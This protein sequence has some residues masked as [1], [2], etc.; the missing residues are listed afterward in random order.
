MTTARAWLLAA[1]VGLLCGTTSAVAQWNTCVIRNATSSG[2]PPAILDNNNYA[3]PAKEFVISEGGQK[4]AWGTSLLDGFAVKDIG[5]I[6]VTRF[7]DRTRFTA[8][9]GP[10][11][12]PYF[13]IWITD[14]T[15]KYAVIA[16]E[17]SDPIFQPLYSNGYNLTWA[18]IADKPAKVYE[19]ADKSW[20]PNNGVGLT[21]NDVADYV[22]QAPTVAE[23][24]TGWA[25]LG[26]GAP[27]ELG[28]NIAYGFNWVLGDTLSNYV[29]GDPGYVLAQPAAVPA[30][31]TWQVATVHGCAQFDILAGS[32]ELL[33]HVQPRNAHGWY[34]YQNNGAPAWQLATGGFGPNGWR[35]GSRTF[36]AT[37][38]AVGKRLDELKLVF[39]Y[40][41]ALGGYTTVNFFITDGNGKFGIFA[42]TSLGINVVGGIVQLDDNWS[43]MTIDLT[44]DATAIP[45][46]TP[47][48]VYEHN[49]FTNEFGEPFTT[50][51]WGDIKGYTIAGMYDYQRSPAGGWS[52]WSRTMFDPINAAGVSS[53]INGYGLALIWGDTVGNVAYTTQQRHIRNV[54]VSFDGVDYQGTFANAQAPHELRLEAEGCQDDFDGDPNNGKQV[55][56]ELWMRNLQQNITGFQAFVAYETSELTFVPTLSSY[57]AVP[58][59]VHITQMLHAESGH[60]GRL[61]LDGSAPLDPNDPLYNGTDSDSLLATLVFTVIAE[62]QTTAASF[63]TYDPP[64]PGGPV[65]ASELSYLGVVVPTI[66]VDSPTIYLDDTPPS[67]TCPADSTI[68]CTVDPVPANTNGSATATDACD[69]TPAI[70]YTDVAT[71]NGCG[72]YTGTIAR[73]WRATDACGNYAECLQTISIVDTTPPVVTAPASVDLE[74]N[75]ALPPA[76]ATITEFLALAGA[77]AADNCST[78]AQLTVTSVTGALV[79]DVCNGTITRTYTIRDACNNATSVDHVFTVTDNTPPVIACPADTTIECDQM[80]LGWANGGILIAYNNNGPENPGNQAWFR[81]QASKAN[82]NGAVFNFEPGPWG[83]GASHPFQVHPDQFGLD[84]TLP[85]L[86]YNGSNPALTWFVA[87]DNVN[88]SCGGAFPAGP[89]A[90]AISGYIPGP[91]SPTGCVVNSV[92]RSNGIVTPPAPVVLTAWNLTQSGTIFTAD[93]TGYLLS[94]GFVHWYTPA[95]PDTPMANLGWNGQFHFRGRLVYNSAG[96]PGN[97][98]DYYAGAMVFHANALPASTG[99]ATAVDNCD[100]APVITFT[101]T[102]VPGSCGYTGTL[103]RTWKATDACG[104]VATCPQLIT[105]VDTTP[106]TFTSVP[107]DVTVNADAGSCTAVLNPPLAMAAAVDNCDPNPTV[108]GVRSDSQPLTAPYPVGQTTITWTAKDC[109]NNAVTA[110]TTVVVQPRNTVQVT[111]QLDGVTA[112]VT[113]CVRFVLDSC[114]AYVDV[115]VPFTGGSYSGP[116]DVPCGPWTQLCAKDRQHTKW[117]TVGLTISGPVYVASATLHLAGGD[118]DNDGDVDIHD[119]TFFLYRFGQ[120]MANYSCPWNGVRDADFSNNGSVGSED[121]TFLTSNW[122]TTSL[123]PCTLPLGGGLEEL[124]GALVARPVAVRVSE[125]APEIGVSVDFNADGV[126]DYKD[127]QLFEQAHGLP[128]K[129]SKAIKASAEMQQKQASTVQPMTPGCVAGN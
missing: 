83:Y 46:S 112:D 24:T 90:W 50:M 117:D 123:C 113:R 38:V 72:G 120:P 64:P 97:D 95:L 78:T 16:N 86:T 103:T 36:A 119:V 93:V 31:T 39:E 44:Q 22:I 75:T 105:V 2:N 23:L 110:T 1:T 77:T 14:G 94:D 63:T 102:F 106:P 53:V 89:H 92:L 20:L 43:R 67:I 19:N 80:P 88:G 32:D 35:D 51:T 34:W 116:I 18:Q 101:D 25:G 79:G 96:D 128:N 3:A 62:C 12:A 125:L 65:F 84:F 17:P 56:F 49:G 59:P 9:S 71:L 122:L 27:R 30:F 55:R 87:K 5:R 68:E 85:A 61:H 99:W 115:D 37:N 129:L 91:A 124:P 58:F 98:G 45:L 108:T 52:K 107:A 104:N 15:G 82:T 48:A 69:P 29:S 33:Y 4:A 121:Y 73:T 11:V 81:A 114:G 126:V 60:V 57:A 109:H 7:D 47:V 100:P 26:T 13:N 28:T 40:E 74:C 6:A 111:V 41:H 54:R 8:G 76:A 70:S 118:T 42:P 21:F 127:V 66:T 10:Y